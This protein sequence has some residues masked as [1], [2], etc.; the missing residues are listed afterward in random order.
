MDGPG[1]IAC[2]CKQASGYS[3]KRCRCR[4]RMRFHCGQ[5]GKRSRRAFNATGVNKTLQIGSVA[6]ILREDCCKSNCGGMGARPAFAC[7]FQS[8]APP[9]QANFSGNGLTRHLAC[10]SKLMVEGVKREEQR[11]LAGRC[12]KAREITIG[13]EAA[14]GCFAGG[15]RLHRA[16]CLELIVRLSAG[17][18][19]GNAAPAGELAHGR[20]DAATMQNSMGIERSV[21]MRENMPAFLPAFPRASLARSG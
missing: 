6:G 17:R 20:C 7:G 2:A 15:K 19:S 18:S 14:Y 9:L 3:H 21:L 10:P 5:C 1:H 13:V 4:S 12:K 8:F 16:H 11:T